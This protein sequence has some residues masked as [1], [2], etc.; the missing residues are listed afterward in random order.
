[1]GAKHD[2][3]EKNRAKGRLKEKIAAVQKFC[4]L[5]FFFS[6]MSTFWPRVLLCLFGPV[7]DT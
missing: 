4:L 5:F 3:A 2:K 6:S 7:M 1:M